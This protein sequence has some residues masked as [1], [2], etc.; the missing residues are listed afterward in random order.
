MDITPADAVAFSL[1]LLPTGMLSS[2]LKIQTVSKLTCH[3]NYQLNLTA[4]SVG[5]I[6]YRRRKG[7][8]K[9]H[10]D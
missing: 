10:Y 2:R 8:L 6:E 5:P 1:S 9:I 4:A 3:K 7:F